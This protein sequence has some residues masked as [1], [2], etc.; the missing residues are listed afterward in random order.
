MEIIAS[1]PMAPNLKGKTKKGVK[2][3]AAPGPRLK[4]F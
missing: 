3:V 4:M 2:T 1:K